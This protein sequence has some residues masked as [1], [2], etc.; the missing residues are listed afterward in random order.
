VDGALKTAETVSEVLD[1]TL[2]ILKPESLDAPPRPL[3][4]LPERLQHYAVELPPTPELLAEGGTSPG[5]SD[6]QQEQQ[7]AE[8]AAPA[9][10][11][12]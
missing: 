4:E 2:M 1:K 9:V 7:A 8:A 10:A 12:A 5:S 3:A 6:G 11:A